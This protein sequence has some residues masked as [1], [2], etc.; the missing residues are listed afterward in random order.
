MIRQDDR[1]GQRSDSPDRSD[2]RLEMTPPM[3]G[4]DLNSV[5][6]LFPSGI[7]QPW[8]SVVKCQGQLSPRSGWAQGNADSDRVLFTNCYSL[9]FKLGD[10]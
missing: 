9:A 1:S 8:G 7:R 5:S 3:N 4:P 10:Q 2:T 6:M